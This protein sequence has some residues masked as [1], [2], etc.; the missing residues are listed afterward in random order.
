MVWKVFHL[1]NING[2][3]LISLK[4]RFFLNKTLHPT[5]QFEAIN[6]R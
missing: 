6:K 1:E 5:H 3:T 4:L 2:L